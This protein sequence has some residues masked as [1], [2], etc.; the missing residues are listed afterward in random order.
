MSNKVHIEDN[1]FLCYDIIDFVERYISMLK[2]LYVMKIDAKQELDNI[3]SQEDMER[4]KKSII[5]PNGVN[6]DYLLNGERYFLTGDKGSGKT[7]LLIYTA[8]KAEEY[9]NAERSFMIFKE[10]SQE[11]RDEY[12]KIAHVTIYDQESIMPYYD[13]ENVWKWLIHKNIVEAIL[14]SNKEIFIS[15]ENLAKY[16]YSV[17]VVETSTPSSKLP[18]FAKDGYIQAE[19][20]IPGFL[21]IASKVNFDF[22]N[23]NKK[24]IKFSS[25]INELNS[26]FSKLDAADSQLYIIVDE[27]NLSMKNIIEF[28]RDV[29]MI[30]DLI[31]V[32]EFM[33]ALS[34]NSHDNVR[35]IGGIRNE[36]INS[37]QAKGKE[38]NKSIESYGIPIDWTIYEED[39][40]EHPLLKI[41]V[42]YLRITDLCQGDR[43]ER[44]N[45]QVYYK[46]VDEKMFGK[47]S[48]E[49]ILQ[50]TLYRPRH[51][52]RMLNLAKMLC[53]DDEKISEL[54]FKKTRKEYSKECWNEAVE[55]L[56]V[57]YNSYQINAIKNLF[58]G[59]KSVLSKEI[60]YKK[61]CDLWGNDPQMVSVV[62]G[63]D[64]FLRSL[65]TVGII[66]NR[67]C[68][69]TNY[70]R[71]YCRGDETLL[72]NQEILVNRIFW[73]VL[74]IINRE[75]IF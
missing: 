71:W 22:K 44:T 72:L 49:I 34:K 27:L 59:S 33:N 3:N 4:F 40:L 69:E 16:I 70:F 51:V 66:G 65:Y 26:L 68:A 23:G 9:F 67:C 17:K 30:R 62:K 25:H 2:N 13:Y 43:K 1:I 5:V 48:E 46:W 57:V 29:M 24:Q 20:N 11:E 18:I 7:A 21:S 36:V 10:I 42:N 73:P 56:S 38:I 32:M 52:V 39:K 47:D 58:A 41:L 8:L 15:N 37:V 63:F 60:I 54:T 61:A 64:D 31:I 53:P 74:S 35:I 6:L 75:R 50:N 12:K 28:E 14:D 55:E 19:I 45:R